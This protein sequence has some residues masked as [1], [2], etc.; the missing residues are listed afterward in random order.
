MRLLRTIGFVLRFAWRDCCS[1]PENRVGLSRWQC[2]R[3]YHLSIGQAAAI[4][5]TI[6]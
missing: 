5:W 4:G 2:W 3:R 6:S 1:L